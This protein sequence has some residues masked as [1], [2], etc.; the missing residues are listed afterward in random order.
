MWVDTVG[1]EISLSVPYAE[2]GAEAGTP[3]HVWV[4]IHRKGIVDRAP[5]T[6]DTDGTED[7]VCLKPGTAAEVI[8]ITPIA[9]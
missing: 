9:D 2:V 1:T 5:D 4:D 3:I 7:P 8:T 6:I